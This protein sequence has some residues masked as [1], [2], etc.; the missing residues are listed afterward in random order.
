MSYATMQDVLFALDL[1]D[2]ELRDRL[3]RH[4]DVPA[5]KP[6]LPEERAELRRAPQPEA[7]VETRRAA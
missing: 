1:T 4:P 6:E 7:V 2:S 3:R 5:A